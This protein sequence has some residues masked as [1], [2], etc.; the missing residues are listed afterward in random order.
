MQPFK[1][2]AK[3]H[4]D[5]HTRDLTSL[6]EKSHHTFQRWVLQIH[7]ISNIDFKIPSP[8]VSI[9]LLPTIGCFQFIPYH[10]DLIQSFIDNFGTNWWSLTFLEPTY[11]RSRSPSI[12]C[13]KWS[14]W[15]TW[16][17]TIII[18]EFNQRQVIFQFP[19]KSI[20]HALN[21]SSRIWIVHST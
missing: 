13:F 6:L 5:P 15:N 1:S 12:K 9:G 7:H 10:T 19:L 8:S 11:R 17:I 18:G 4:S 14:D 3:P 2:F 16:M 21:I 20:T